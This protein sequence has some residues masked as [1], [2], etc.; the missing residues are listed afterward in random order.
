MRE[1]LLSIALLIQSPSQEK[2][3]EPTDILMLS[4]KDTFG[5]GCP[6]EAPGPIVGEPPQTRIFTAELVAKDGKKFTPVA[7]AT[8]DGTAVGFAFPAFLDAVHDL[9]ILLPQEAPPFAFKLSRR[10]PKEGEK[11]T[12]VGYRRKGRNP[13]DPFVVEARFSGLGP[14]LITYDDSPGPGSSGSCVLNSDGEV[15]AINTGFWTPQGPNGPGYGIGVSLFSP[16][17]EKRIVKRIEEEP[18]E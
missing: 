3:I 7:W 12:I 9:V 1:L 15:V 4:G 11:L 6:V 13:Y 16:W 8:H 18:D 14:G 10:P 17:F 5:H 2:S